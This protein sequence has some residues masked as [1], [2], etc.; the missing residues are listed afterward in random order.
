M[1]FLAAL[2]EILHYIDTV[3][4]PVHSAP[5][6]C[7]PEA[8]VF[9]GLKRRHLQVSKMLLSPKEARKIPKDEPVTEP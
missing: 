6:S 7:R 3:T 2:I 8:R 4:P 5:L 1:I 9:F